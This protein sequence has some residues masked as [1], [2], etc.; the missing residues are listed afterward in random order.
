MRQVPSAGDWALLI[1]YGIPRRQRRIDVVLLADTV[2]FVLEFKVGATSYSRADLWQAEDYAL[3]LRDFH[4][5]SHG[6]TIVPVLVATE[7][8]SQEPWIAG[9]LDVCRVGSTGLADC[10][11]EAYR[12]H[13][14]KCSLPPIQPD[15]WDQ[16]S[17][18]PTPTI[19]DAT[20]QLF[21]QHTVADLSHSYAD[22]LDGTVRAIRDACVS[23]RANGERLICFVTG[24]PGAGKTLAG[25]AAVHASESVSAS[26]LGAYLSGNGPLVRVLREA[27]ARDA[28]ER[29]STKRDAM[30]RA[31]LLIQNVHEFVE[32]Y[33]VTRTDLAPPE[34]I[35]VFDEAQRAWHE[36]KLETRHKG[37]GTSEPG[38]MLAAMSRLPNW[39]AIIA[40]VGGG[41]EIHSGEAGLAEWGRAIGASEDQWH[42][43]ASPEV[44]RGGDSVAFHQLFGADVPANARVTE[45][46]EMHLSVSVRSPRAAL[47]GGVGQRRARLGPRPRVRVHTEDRRLSSGTYARSWCCTSVAPGRSARR[48]SCRFACEFRQPSSSRVR[49]RDVARFSPWVSDPPLVPR[50]TR[51]RSVIALPGSRVDRVRVS[52]PGDRLRRTLLG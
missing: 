11:A 4:E 18:R 41:Q 28:A 30:H 22:N 49:T 52:R 48:L 7:A 14:T 23:A 24:V 17:Y 13:R 29:G 10:I 8:A 51:G 2:V 5:G 44:L 27:I 16:A 32:E 45:S 25:L 38:L 26:A 46:P 21:A 47:P 37:I 6:R 50:L 36:Q 40:L 20:Q 33:G 31:R 3:D 35:V 19:V 34:Q 9:T 12:E 43:L 42:I 39:C 1:E 15:A